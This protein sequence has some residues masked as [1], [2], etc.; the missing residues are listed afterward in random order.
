VKYPE[1]GGELG[2]FRIL[3]ELG[4]GSFG[5]VYLAEQLELGG[6][7][8]ALKVAPALG[9]EPECLA[10]LQHT[11]IVPIFSV[12]D[13]II[14]KMRIIC[15]P[16]YGGANLAQILSRCGVDRANQATG[17]SLLDALD[18]APGDARC[19]AWSKQATRELR[20]SRVEGLVPLEAREGESSGGGV[21]GGASHR[22]S[23]RVEG[24]T[25]SERASRVRSALGRYFAR[26]GQRAGA[27]SFIE[28]GRDGACEIPP[29]RLGA[30]ARQPAR[31]F[32]ARNS[33]VRCCAWIIARLAEALEHAH[34]RG[35]L[36]RDLKPSNILIAG[37][38]M[39]MLL[40]FN[41]SVQIRDEGEELGPARLGGT[42]PYMSPEHL[43][44]FDPEGTTPA[45]DVDERSDVYS[46]GLILYEM[47]AGVLPFSDQ[48]LG[49]R[50]S[51]TIRQMIQERLSGAPGVRRY[52]AAVPRSLESIVGRCLQAD[53]A[54][55]YQ[56]AG[57]LAE[58]LRCFLDDRP[59]RTAAD[60]S[61]LE[62]VARWSRRHPRW[63]SGGGVGAAALVVLGVVATG[64]LILAGALAVARAREARAGFLDSFERAQVELNT[65]GQDE[66]RAAL[67]IA[68]AVSVLETYGVATGVATDWL[69]R[70]LVR[71]LPPAEQEAM[72][73]E[74]SELI[75]LMARARVLRAKRGE[76]RVYR[77]ALEQAV[78]WLDRAVL[79][80]P[81]PGPALHLERSMYLAELGREA[82]AAESWERAGRMRAET[83]RDFYLVGT[84]QAAS[85]RYAEAAASLERAI[86]LEPRRFWARF[87]QGMC[88]LELEE[89]GLAA[90]DFGVCTSLR[91]DFAWAHANRGLALARAGRHEEARH[92]Y[93]VAIGLEPDL[94]EARYNRALL[95]L[96]LG[97][98]RGALADLAVMGRGGAATAGQ[99]AAEAEAYRLLGEVARAEELLEGALARDS[100]NAELLLVR[101]LCRLGR[102]A[103][104]A[105]ADFEAV[106][107]KDA[108]N[109][110]A[111]VGLARVVRERDAG[112]ALEALG[113]AIS[114]DPEHDEAWQLRALLRARAGDL[115]ALGD[116]DRLLARPKRWNVYNAACAY[117]LLGERGHREYLDRARECLGRAIGAGVMEATARADADLRVLYAEGSGEE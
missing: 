16:Y 1:P 37:D 28:P 110:R 70:P 97:D 102:D 4:R 61:V 91:P 106:L 55:R 21:N 35:L 44:A 96:E 69:R 29:A 53:P 13:D 42:L 87:V 64:S 12:H 116:I 43:D 99:L 25:S 72:R 67:G 46:L 33:Y 81:E 82:A 58:D 6:R 60:P 34:G 15:M 94:R 88:H 24:V 18:E 74:M 114:L 101:G 7:R 11:H 73:R 30:A 109:V 47:L 41:L 93:D 76:P 20:G 19:F 45:A 108:R 5:R 57:E 63:T 62:R 66:G 17:K 113:R 9:E 23:A 10:R 80:D 98:A 86:A 112:S 103:A 14:T 26:F 111:W 48:A 92:A 68:R 105:R 8:V 56:S 65:L 85:G 84:M 89:Y 39:P 104:G 83:A 51:A 117:A 38:G 77:A 59:L 95:L 32:L 71:H 49:G 107:A 40:D 50:V 75:Q 100:E 2:G 27:S 115:A 79:F 31:E 36:H 78:A 22:G 54:G 3:S 52:N 90:G